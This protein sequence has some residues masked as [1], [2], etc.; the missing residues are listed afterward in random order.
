MPLSFSRFRTC[1]W[2]K[3][4]QVGTGGIVIGVHCRMGIGRSGMIAAGILM[5]F[6]KDADQAF[7]EVSLVR[8]RPVPDTQEQLE[9][10]SRLPL[11]GRGGFGIG[12]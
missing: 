4:A 3:G 12:K 2:G 6:G 8:G 9:W 1:F 10:V 7:S 5:Y 11:P